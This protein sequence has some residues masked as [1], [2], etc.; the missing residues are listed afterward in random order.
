MVSDVVD[1]DAVCVAVAASGDLG[2]NVDFS[3]YCVNARP[4]MLFL[5]FKMVKLPAKYGIADVDDL[6]L[7]F[8]M[9]Y[10]RRA[11]GVDIARA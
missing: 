7:I 1:V 3:R 11:V 9:G 10:V 5:R 8:K 6:L 4:Y 2:V